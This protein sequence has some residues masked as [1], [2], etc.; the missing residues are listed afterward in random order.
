MVKAP[1]PAGLKGKFKPWRRGVSK[2]SKGSVK[3]QL[4]GQERLLKRATSD[5]QRKAIQSQIDELRRQHQA[6]QER[7]IERQHAQKSHGTR[8]LERQ[9]LTRLLRKL[10]A[11][12]ADANTGGDDEE[13]AAA[14]AEREAARVRLA[15]DQAYVGHFPHDE[16]YLKLFRNGQRVVDPPKYLARRARIRARILESI[17]AAGSVSSARSLP[18]PRVDWISP[19]QYARLPSSWSFE[20]ER[21]VFG[22]KGGN[23]AEKATI[24]C[25][26]T[27]S[28]GRFHSRDA[29]EELIQA[30]EDAER[31]AAMESE[32]Y[33]ND[34]IGD[35]DGN[36]NG[37][38]SHDEKLP[39]TGKSRESA[40]GAVSSSG[41]ELLCH[42]VDE[43]SA[44]S[45][46]G[47]TSSD[48][49]SSSSSD[50]SSSSSSE[51]CDE[52]IPIKE[53]FDR[54]IKG[55][56]VA[57]G[58][59][60]D[61]KASNEDGGDN[62]GG[63]GDDDFFVEAGCEVYNNPFAGAPEIKSLDQIRGDKSQG[64]AT[65]RQRPGEYKKKKR[66]Q[67]ANQWT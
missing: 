12:H 2:K 41:P 61:G 7:E 46:R 66:Q 49:D 23:K 18:P 8:F 64:W 6:R 63:G 48:G 21:R 4:R 42:D 57:V 15:L 19:E 50:D 47:T 1:S 31:R 13:E 10:V 24:T 5:E 44:G 62:G 28:D 54:E 45:S 60:Y 22:V 25:T 55:C 26:A 33:E 9:R 11:A 27:K 14:A 58:T 37:S 16:K 56:E 39:G 36:G 32:D 43:E 52:D 35:G 38:D 53:T 65:Q 40:V 51:D 59:A 67:P 20:D 17:A 29:H 30:A 3:N 34:G